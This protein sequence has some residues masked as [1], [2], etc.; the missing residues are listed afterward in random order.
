MPRNMV[1][2]YS[3]MGYEI[4]SEVQF[5]NLEKTHHPESGK[6]CPDRKHSILDEDERLKDL[7]HEEKDVLL[8][9]EETIDSLDDDVEEEGLHDS[10]VFCN[11]PKLVEENTPD[12]PGSEELI[13]L[14]PSAPE[15]STEPAS[16][17]TWKPDE[18]KLEDAEPSEEDVH[19]N[20]ASLQP[21]L[22]PP[23]PLPVYETHSVQPAVLHPKLLH[24]IPTPLLIAEKLSEQKAEGSSSLLPSPKERNPNKRR[25]LSTSSTL[26]SWEQVKTCAPPPTAPKPQRFPSNISFTNASEREFSKIISK[27]AVNVQERKAQVLANV[28][29]SALLMNELE[30]RLKK[31]G[32]LDP[33]QSL[34]LRDLPSESTGHEPLSSLSLV[35]KTLARA[36]LIHPLHVLSAKEERPEQGCGAPNGYQNIHEIMKRNPNLL[37]TLN[38]TMSVKLDADLVDGKSAWSSISG[39]P[40]Q[41]LILDM[42]RK[43]SSLP[44]SAG[45]QSKG[46]TVQFSGRGSTEE[47]RRE[48]LR[49]L[50]LLKE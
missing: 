37:P 2:D 33:S 36:H 13:E 15:N 41:D 24:S 7:T 16:E 14:V 46:V 1:S 17:E 8:F 47:A 43:L 30:E 9:F 10:G 48:A 49:K 42:Q 27:A 26:C 6:N 18:P 21:T 38:K 39:Q 45:L 40:Q 44:K 31:R 35:E 25:T 11:S 28:N 12:H 29:A 32:F 50:G 34:P 22:P 3:G 19:V 5:G 23:P 4:P 20:P